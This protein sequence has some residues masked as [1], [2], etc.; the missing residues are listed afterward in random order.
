MR[1]LAPLLTVAALASVW[2]APSFADGQ[3]KL[4][5]EASKEL[6]SLNDEM[7][8]SLNVKPEDLEGKKLYVRAHVQVKD[9]GSSE[10]KVDELYVGEPKQQLKAPG[11]SIVLKGTLKE[12]TDRTWKLSIDDVIPQPKQVESKGVAADNGKKE[13]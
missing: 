9:G 3:E 13:K 8:K 4:M 6:I 10:L 2:A 1:R 12:Q 11:D 5:K 7:L